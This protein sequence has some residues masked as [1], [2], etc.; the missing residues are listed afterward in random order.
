MLASFDGGRF[1]GAQ[2]DSLAA[3]GWP[4]WRLVV[5]DDGSSD[6]TRDIVG[7]FARRHPD[8]DIRLVDGPRQGATR[9]FLSLLEQAAPDEWI[10]FCDQ[11]D[12][13]LP[14]RLERGLRMIGA[15][16][17]PA[18]T[19]SRTLICDDALRPVTPAPLFR[20]PPAFRNALVQ[21]C[22][23]G[24]TF[25]ANPQAA[26]LLRGGAAAA[27]QAGVISH[28]WW[29][30]QLLTGAG[31]LVV[32]DPEP[33]VLYRQ[34]HGNVMGR[35][36]TLRAR[37]ARI[38][39]LGSGDYGGWLQANIRAL[40]GARGLLTPENAA[41]LDCFEAALAAPGPLAAARLKRMGLHRQTA[42]GT[43]AL[44]VAAAAGKLRPVA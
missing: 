42:A 16:S 41:L 11:D 1:I 10:A 20:R 15:A 32:R 44:L 5:S 4:D 6:G 17:G 36:D 8:R 28:D 26:A 7:E 3:Q 2:L 29:A 33:T 24:N 9:N 23:P 38:A 25:L 39:M 18:A 19:S 35:N 34:H 12:A 31:A 37:L 22:L 14:Q 21:A 40:Q 43:L 30:Y 13:W 27:A